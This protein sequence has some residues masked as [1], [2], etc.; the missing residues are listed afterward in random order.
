MD[1]SIM[2]MLKH[3]YDVTKLAH[4]ARI[5]RINTVIPVHFRTAISHFVA[6]RFCQC[7]SQTIEK[8]SRASSVSA[9]NES[10]VRGNQK[11]LQNQHILVSMLKSPWKTISVRRNQ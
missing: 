8:L 1:H 4:G 5:Y 6:A 7:T 2:A 3:S 9:E 10:D 11:L